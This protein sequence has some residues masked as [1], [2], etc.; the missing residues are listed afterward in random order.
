MS[1]GVQR[2]ERFEFKYW[3]PMVRVEAA[4]KLLAGFMQED[5]VAKQAG[6]SQVNTSLYL[7]SP[8]FTFLEQHVSGSP[9]RIKLRVRYYGLAP[10]G[11]CFFEIKRRQ[12]AVVMKKRAVV[13]LDETRPFLLDVTKAL[14]A[15]VAQNEAMQN[16]QYLALRCQAEPKLLVRAQR[17]AYRSVDV[18]TD[19]RLTVDTEIAWQPTRGPDFLM[20]REGL[21]RYVGG[22]DVAANRA[23]V[24]VKFRDSR[25][26][27]LGEVVQLL[28]PFRVSFSK[29]V[30]AAIEA[31]KDPFFTSDAA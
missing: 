1:D 23:L 22:E 14:P 18:G 2:F 17:A 15:S 21:W 9:D 26:W 20:P 4:L 28:G 25:P 16:F 19:V 5:E 24:E 29:Y 30:A 7:D 3:A 11:D 13:S 27:W 10:K 8:R 31:R 6:A 12:N